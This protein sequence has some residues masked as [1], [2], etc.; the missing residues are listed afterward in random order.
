MKLLAWLRAFLHVGLLLA[1][2]H[3]LTWSTS[4]GLC[5][6]A[7]AHAKPWLENEPTVMG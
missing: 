7:E 3:D 1:T 2:K 5:H 4:T 6:G